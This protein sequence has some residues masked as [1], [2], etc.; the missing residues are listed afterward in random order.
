[1]F[2]SEGPDSAHY[3]SHRLVVLLLLVYVQC[4]SVLP[5]AAA[6]T[7]PDLLSFV[8]LRYDGNSL[9]E[10]LYPRRAENKTLVLFM[11]KDE[12]WSHDYYLN[13]VFVPKEHF[14]MIF[15]PDFQ[16]WESD[17][18]Y[19]E[20]LL[21]LPENQPKII[22]YDVS[23]CGDDV[24]YPVMR[25]LISKYQPRVLVH[26]ADEYEGWDK[27]WRYGEGTE[28]YKLVPLVLRQYSV[29]PYQ[30]YAKPFGHVMHVPLGYMTDMLDFKKDVVN[31][32]LL[33]HTS[34]GDFKHFKRV[35]KL[36]KPEEAY[37]EG[38]HG[39][40]SMLEA[41]NFFR[42][43]HPSKT[44]EY[45]WSFIGIIDG[46]PWAR[47]Q[48]IEAFNTTNPGGVID[49]GLTPKEMRE[50][51]MQSKFVVVGKGHRNLECFRMYEAIVSGAIPVVA[52]ASMESLLASLDFDGDLP[53]F[54][55]YEPFRHW[56]SS[57][58]TLVAE[59]VKNMNDSHIN[60][61]RTENEK[62]LIRV[63]QR[64]RNRLKHVLHVGSLERANSRRHLHIHTGE[65][66]RIGY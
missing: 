53:P 7:E 3:L 6:S 38:V 40:M 65:H 32:P 28:L 15:W 18:A 5:T 33:V 61:I 2:L 45:L 49:S 14:R 60:F 8:P 34:G 13:D 29:S 36:P 31:G 16:Q 47:H 52:D 62:W 48:I 23:V 54:V 21:D 50:V 37:L 58:F 63:T 20:A 42:E 22:V 56:S 19:D 24:T 64:T 46:H 59:D 10:D 4:M 27:K 26:E 12:H 17:N 1:M 9:D 55:T 41:I 39:K 25:K 43:W 66:L 30:S 51:Y 57:N 44:R 11:Y 35:T